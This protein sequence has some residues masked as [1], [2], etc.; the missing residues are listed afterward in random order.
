MVC[1][2]DGNCREQ[3]QRVEEDIPKVAVRY[4]MQEDET[5]RGEVGVEREQKG[6]KGLWPETDS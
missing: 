4:S 2:N 1:H 3:I 5:K 6:S